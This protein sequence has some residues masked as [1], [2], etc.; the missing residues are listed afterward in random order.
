MV[1]CGWPLCYFTNPSNFKTKDDME[2]VCN[3]LLSETCYFT[4]IMQAE[5]HSLKVKQAQRRQK[6]GKV[7][8]LGIELAGG[9]AVIEESNADLHGNA[10]SANSQP[11]QPPPLSPP[12]PP[13]PPP[14][15]TFQSVFQAAA[16][17][18]AGYDG[19]EPSLWPPSAFSAP[20]PAPDPSLFS[21]IPPGNHWPTATPTATAITSITPPQ[22]SSATAAE[23]PAPRKHRWDYGLDRDL[24][25]EVKNLATAAGLTPGEYVDQHPE[26]Y[27]QSKKKRASAARSRLAAAEA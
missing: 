13:P 21:T 11:S 4:K 27:E 16:S 10:R 9:S 2:A 7:D 24:S 18:P 5:L 12:P 3:A 19:S 26:I 20:I 1:L 8:D 14:I 25:R 17:V 22:S 6:G 15:Q 23:N